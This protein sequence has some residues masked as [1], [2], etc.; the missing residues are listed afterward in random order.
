MRAVIVGA[1]I[2]GLAAAQGLRLIGWDVAVYEQAEKVEPLGAGLSLSAN[3]L[4]ALRALGLYEAVAARA[5]PIR[6]LDLLDQR[7]KVLQTTDFEE[8]SRRYDH[9]AMAVLHRADL[10]QGLLSKLEDGVIRTGMECVGA[11]EAGDR[12]VLHFANG[13]AVE[14]DFVLACDGIHSAVR[15]ALF[16]AAREHFARYTCWR[17]ISPGVPRG[18]DPA[19]LSES[20]GAG[21]RFGLAAIPG[22]RVYWF[23]CCGAGRTDDPGLA[24]LD[25][26]GVGALFADFHEP[27]PEVLGR[28]PPDSLIWTDI[29]DLEPMP[30]FTRGKVVLLG[31]AAHAVTPDLGQGAGLAIEDAAV[32]SALLARLPMERALQEYDARRVGRACRI[33]L[34]SRLYARVAQWR[35]PLVVPLRNFLVSSI[36]ERLLDRQ[37][38]AVLDVSFDPIRT[39]A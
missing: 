9:L 10:H 28:T 18:M 13:D 3:A 26:E 19:R 31:D 27:V 20:W 6:R 32:L 23:A 16:P 36:P 24:K 38:D 37:L 29:L 1:G 8:F 22:D 25:L 21:R 30:S 35:N 15:K 17:A 11:R 14:A 5:Q 2:A 39:A 34:E 7:G 4:R 33:A 12:I